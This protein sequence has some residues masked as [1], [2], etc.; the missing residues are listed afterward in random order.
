MVP[1]SAAAARQ[2]PD[3]CQRREDQT[4]SSRHA[5][6]REKAL[7]RGRMTAASPTRWAADLLHQYVSVAN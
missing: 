6:L 1:A 2:D 4:R 3:D 7:G 5:D